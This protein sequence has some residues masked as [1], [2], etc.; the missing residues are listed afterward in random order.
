M[1]PINY[2]TVDLKEVRRAYFLE[3]LL[4]TGLQPADFKECD[5]D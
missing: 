4:W 5:A 1:T 2:V 3:K